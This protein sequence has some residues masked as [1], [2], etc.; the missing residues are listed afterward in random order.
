MDEWRSAG[1]GINPYVQEHADLIASIRAGAPLN[2]TKQV[3]DSTL[4]AIMG[5]ESAYSGKVVDFESVLAMNSIMPERFDMNMSLPAPV[6][7]VP[8]VYKFD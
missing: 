7:A 2:E 4:T 3:T 8:G 6:P 5:R 1:G